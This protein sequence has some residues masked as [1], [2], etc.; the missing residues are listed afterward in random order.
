MSRLYVGSIL[1]SGLVLVFMLACTQVESPQT[2]APTHVGGFTPVLG[3]T[4]ADRTADTGDPATSAPGRPT[5]SLK[6]QIT[7]TSVETD[8]QALTNLFNAT[9]GESWDDSATWASERPLVDWEGVVTNSEGRVVGLTLHFSSNDGQPKGDLLAEVHKLT[10][11]RSLLVHSDRL[12][13]IPRELGYLSELRFLEMSGNSVQG[14]IPAELGELSNLVRLYID[15]EAIEGE[16]PQGIFELPRLRELHIYG[17]GL[18]LEISGAV[19]SLILGGVWMSLG[20]EATT[21]CLSDLAYTVGFQISSMAENGSEVPVCDNVHEGDLDVL[22]EVFSEWRDYGTFDGWL[23]RL[24]VKEWEG[25]TIDRN[26]RVVDLYI[27]GLDD[28]DVTPDSLPEAIEGLI[29][30]QRLELVTLGI[31][32]EIPGWIGNLTQLEVLDLHENDFSGEIPSWIADLTRL[33]ELL[34]SDNNLS[35]EVPN[36][37]STLPEL[38][39]IDLRGNDLSGCLPEPPPRPEPISRFSSFPVGPDGELEIPMVIPQLH[40]VEYCP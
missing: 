29:A 4:E 15:A 16:V 20:V 25:I 37:I 21:G 32:G 8:R 40:G 27:R 9:D 7:N 26:G 39:W 14:Q 24:P 3:N 22:R 12:E 18:H 38:Q 13:P 11:L 1:L 19:E 2:T 34:L 17:E 5:G 6:P 31:K 28:A 23:T 30:L 33:Q 36:F 35:G 10:E